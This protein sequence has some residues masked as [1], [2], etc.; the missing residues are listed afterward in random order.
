MIYDPSKWYWIVDGDQSRVWS[1][2][3]AGFVDANDETYA[4]WLEG[5]GGPTPIGSL[6]ELAEVFAAQYPGG[7]LDTYASFC[8]WRKEVGDITVNGISV[9]TDDRSK[10]MITGARLAAEADVNF[11]TPW[12]G[13]DGSITTLNATQVIAISDAVLAHVQSCFSTFAAVSSGIA[14]ETVTTRQQIDAAFS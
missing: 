6:I 9:A 8:R 10:Q 1:S 11:T 3:S 4:A 12:V 14:D 5:G 7:M 2:A 13:T